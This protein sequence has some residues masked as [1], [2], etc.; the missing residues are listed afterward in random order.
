[1]RF[2]ILLL[3]LSIAP[4]TLVQAQT[5]EINGRVT[6]GDEPVVGANIGIQEL[7]IGNST[8]KNGYFTIK[9]VP[10]GTHQ[11]R[12]S[13]IGYAAV[14]KKVTVGE[15]ETIELNIDMESS[16]L[17]LD[18]VVVTG[19][20]RETYVKESPVK[21]AVVNAQGLQKGKTSSNIMDLISNIGGLSTQL[22]C[23]V[24]GTNAIRIN[25]VEG[26]NTAVLI[27]GMPIMGAL[28]SVYG[29]NGIS[30]SIIDQV[31]VI[32]GPQSTLYGTEALG[33]VVNIITK[34]PKNTPGFSAEIFGKST[35]EGS[36][37]L[38][39]T[40]K[41]G[42]FQGFVSGDLLRMENYFDRNDDNFN[43]VAKR[44]RIALFGKGTLAGPNGEQMLNVA[45]KLY[46]E[47]R[48]GGVKAFSD[49]M[50]GSDQ[51]YGESIYTKRAELL[52]E[53]RPLGFDQRLRFSGALTFHNQDSYYGTDHYDAQQNIVYGQ[54]TWDQPVTE[55][56]QLLLG[57]T[58]R[59][60]TYDDNTPATSDGTNHRFIPGLFAQSEASIGDITLLA[61]LRVDHH[62]EHGFVTAP[63]LSAKFSPSARTTFRASGGTGFRVVNVFTEDHAALTGSREVVFAEDLDPEQ[64]RSL[65]AS[66]EH[67][68]PLGTNPLTV[69]LD[70]FYTHFT[71][72]IIPDYDQDPNLIVYEN[73]DGFSVTRGV[74]IDLD[75]SLTAIPLSYNA[76]FTL[77]DVFTEENGQRQSLTYAPDYI[78]SWGASYLLRFLDL[79]I[80]YTGNLVGPKRMPE[81]YVTQFGRDRWSPTYTT[82]DLKLTKE[83]TNVNSANGVGFEAYLSVENIFDYTQGSPLVDASAPFGPQFDTIY[84]W[85]PIVGRTVS[86]GTRLNLR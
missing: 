50:R 57:S 18:Q 11:L 12:V 24:C 67:V 1:M 27:D 44:S 64:S 9:R 71:N 43:D 42:R 28:A 58:V 15:G 6:S 23:G 83:F 82:H 16:T 25:G 81:N 59:Y 32:K 55:S 86:L 84:T 56:I 62:S 54:A 73:L 17:E 21:V 63:R 51:I 45:A 8:D 22:N 65:T 40:P 66:I 77:M 41:I 19:T 31:E 85:G 10:T 20:M 69:N 72:K 29:L 26:P 3:L 46:D 39:A 79:S 76:S 61:G 47:N 36:I 75:H 33:G 60:Q 13:A 5:G 4:L 35:E 30:P 34:N 38:A 2:Y 37:N 53:Y 14:R 70:G 78:G 74:S 48:T 80:G 7:Q 52:T 49:K 68:F